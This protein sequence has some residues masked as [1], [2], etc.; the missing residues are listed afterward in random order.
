M[1]VDDPRGSGVSGSMKVPDDDRPTARGPH[2]TLNAMANGVVG[3]P[4]LNCLV[5]RHDPVPQARQGAQRVGVAGHLESMDQV[6]ERALR[7]STAESPFRRQIV[8]LRASHIDT[9]PHNCLVGR[10][11]GAALRRFGVARH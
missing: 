6:E 11:V 10:V 1:Q 7:S 2:S 4:R 5:P 9:E 8:R 3:E